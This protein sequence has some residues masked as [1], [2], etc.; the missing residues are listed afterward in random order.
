MQSGL[1]FGLWLVP[2]AYGYGAGPNV[3]DRFLNYFDR[4]DAEYG[5]RAT[6]IR[7]KK[8]YYRTMHATAGACQCKPLREGLWKLKA[9]K[10]ED[11]PP[12]QDV[13]DWL[14]SEA[15]LAEHERPNQT[16]TNLYAFKKEEHIPW[17]S[18]DDCLVAAHCDVVSLSLGGVVGFCVA[19]SKSTQNE[20]YQVGQ[21]YWRRRYTGFKEDLNA[22][23]LRFCIPLQH[24]D[25]LVMSG[26]FQ[27]FLQHKTVHIV[28]GDF[29][30]EMRLR[31]TYTGTSPGLDL[32]W[33][34]LNSTAVASPGAGM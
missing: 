8:R 15:A 23:G 6:A 30:E 22:E 32:L 4:V 34:R 25:V 27:R 11:I 3:I 16:G 13:D 12:L 9:L 5:T 21:S 19:P 26:S 29:G 10:I 17:H 7:G 33:R 14:R 1:G 20:W 24:G 18:D 2:G 31:P 28:K